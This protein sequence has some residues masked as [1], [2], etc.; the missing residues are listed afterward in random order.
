MRQW[1]TNQPVREPRRRGG[2]IGRSPKP[3]EPL[4]G[5]GRGEPRVRAP[6]KVEN[7]RKRP[8]GRF[9]G[10]RRAGSGTG[11]GARPVGEGRTS[12]ANWLYRTGKA[13]FGRR[14]GR[15][16][17]PRFPAVP[18]SPRSDFGRG[19]GDS[20]LPL[21]SRRPLSGRLSPVHSR[22]CR[23]FGFLPGD[24]LWV[25]GDCV[26]T[27]SRGRWRWRAFGEGLGGGYR[28]PPNRI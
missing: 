9:Q 11:V 5:A 22:G 13:S 17:F 16:G 6:A 19:I 4:Q 28:T 27:R 7:A 12:S 25:F 26:A 1:R 18:K 20:R 23:P 24:R 14:S 10:H 15:V 3:H 21:S 8:S 2:K